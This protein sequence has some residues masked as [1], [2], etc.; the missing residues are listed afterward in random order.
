MFTKILS[1]Q[2]NLGRTS[3]FIPYLTISWREM[4]RFG[5]FYISSYKKYIC[6]EFLVAFLVLFL[7]CFALSLSLSLSVSLCLSLSLSLCVCFV[8]FYLVFI[9]NIMASPFWKGSTLKWKSF[10]KHTCSNIM[11]FLPPKNKKK[12]QIKNSDI[13]HISAQNIDFGYSLE[14]HRRGGSNKYPQSMFL[15]EIRK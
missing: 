8:L 10:W 6:C 3:N 2:R 4:N 1:C 11:K 15:A 14:P 13:F 5:G 7:F 12:N 9:K